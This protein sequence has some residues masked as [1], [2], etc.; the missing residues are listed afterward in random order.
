[1]TAIDKATENDKFGFEPYVKGITDFI[2]QTISDDLPITIGIYGA[3]GS[4]KTSFIKQMKKDLTS[5]TPN[6]LPTVWFEAWKYDRT[7]DVRSALIYTILANLHKNA[8]GKTKK[9]IKQAF[10][11]VMAATK[12]LALNTQ[13]SVDAP[14]T[15]ITLPTFSQ[16]IDDINK[17]EKFRT[18][19]D[20]LADGFNKAVAAFLAQ[21][22]KTEQKKLVI[23]VDDLDRCLPEHVITVLEALKIFLDEAPCAFVIAVDR[24]VVEKAIQNHYGSDPGVS[25]RDYLDKII[26]YPFTL[27]P[28]KT[29]DLEKYLGKISIAEKIS[30]KGLDVLALAADGNPRTYLRLNTSWKLC[31]SLA[32]Q[33]IPDLWKDESKRHVIA[34]A[35]VLHLLWPE[36]Y[37]KSRVNPNGLIA[38]TEYCLNEPSTGINSALENRHSNEFQQY[39]ENGPIHHFLSNLRKVGANTGEIFGSPEALKAAL[40]LCS[41]G[42]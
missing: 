19:V 36:I 38:L 30:K 26:Q 40:D 2:R 1:M 31:A 28:A 13:I 15:S 21:Q 16:V 39:W 14:A 34:I 23:F 42:T 12:T 3:W 9:E 6:K 18:S 41:R 10:T 7:D 35:I 25:G 27:P 24:T 8:K 29:S 17:A 4:G 5:D 20:S 11:K 22:S 32:Q 33:V 37:E